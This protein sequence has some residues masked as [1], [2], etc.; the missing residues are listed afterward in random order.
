VVGGNKSSVTIGAIDTKVGGANNVPLWD[1][2]I[3]K[4]IFF[5]FGATVL[6]IDN[7]WGFV[8]ENSQ[9]EDSDECGIVMSQG[10]TGTGNAKTAGAQIIGSKIIQN[11]KDASPTCLD[12]IKLSGVTNTRIIGNEI[13]TQASGGFGVS[14]ENADGTIVIGND[15]GS[16][17]NRTGGIDIDSSSDSVVMI[18]NVLTGLASTEIQDAGTN[19]TIFGNRGDDAKTDS[20]LTQDAFMFLDASAERIY[21]GEG[22]GTNRSFFTENGTLQ[23]EGSAVMYVSQGDNAFVLDASPL[24]GF[25]FGTTEYE[26]R[27]T[28]GQV[29]ATVDVTGDPGKIT[30]LVGLDGIGSV[31]LDYGSASITDHTFTTDGTGTAEI[32]LPAGAI[33]STEIL[34]ATIAIGDLA[35]GTDGQLIT[36]NEAGVA[37]TI[38]TGTSGQVLT[39]NGA[40]TQPT[41]QAAGA[42]TEKGG[43]NVII[44]GG[45]SAITTGEL[46]TRYYAPRACT[47][48]S[49]TATSDVSGSIAVAVWKDTYANFPP[50]SAD[51]ISASASIKI[52]GAIKN[53]DSTLTGWSK[54]VS[55]GDWLIFNV[56][57]AATLTEVAIDLSCDD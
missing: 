25:G 22:S 27:G 34:D 47:I 20:G 9:I 2:H 54:S 55:A 32:V 29:M 18:G 23:F 15:F 4:S 48:D 31:D 7:P 24:A 33:D 13:S 57:S 10:G 51:I 5:D 14:L 38:I 35:N 56:V 36:W 37:S 26:F 39:S 41:F 6:T 40:G 53:T 42:A 44:S 16:G 3:H 1:L 11:G 30:T 45:G 17:D 46:A 12:G 19:S 8:F 52:T 28:S 50:T 43:W 49:W 21:F